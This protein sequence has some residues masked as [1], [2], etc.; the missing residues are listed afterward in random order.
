MIRSIDVEGGTIT[1]YRNADGTDDERII[2]M[3]IDLLSVLADAL[4][5]KVEV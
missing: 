2:T 1:F 5:G 4:S 3:G